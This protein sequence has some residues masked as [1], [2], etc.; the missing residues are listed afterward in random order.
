MSPTS[1]A[2]LMLIAFLIFVS[3]L[4]NHSKVWHTGNGQNMYKFKKAA[5]VQWIK[6]PIIISYGHVI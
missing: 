5:K 2:N 3:D 6:D 1:G 4:K